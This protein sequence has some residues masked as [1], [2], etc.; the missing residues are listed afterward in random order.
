MDVGGGGRGWREP[1][2][3]AQRASEQAGS[4][5]CALQKRWCKRAEVLLAAS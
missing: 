2:E 1:K 3:Q 5:S 4:R